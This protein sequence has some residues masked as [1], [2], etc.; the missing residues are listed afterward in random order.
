MPLFKLP[1]SQ[2]PSV[3]GTNDDVFLQWRTKE[4]KRWSRQSGKYVG[5]TTKVLIF[6]YNLE[7][8]EVL[9]NRKGGTR[10]LAVYLT[11]HRGA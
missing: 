2:Q 3:Y 10:M 7:K 9:I 6:W 5:P 4:D 1:L 11:W 8:I